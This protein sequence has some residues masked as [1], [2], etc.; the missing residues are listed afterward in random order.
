MSSSC[1]AAS[2]VAPPSQNRWG[3]DVGG[4]THINHDSLHPLCF[5]SWISNTRGH[6]CFNRNNLDWWNYGSDG[7]SNNNG[8]ARTALYVR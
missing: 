3:L 6:M 4:G 7:P 1:P 2:S 5:G 8:N